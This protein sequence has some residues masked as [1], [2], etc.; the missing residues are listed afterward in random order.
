MFSAD[1]LP[2]NYPWAEETEEK[3]GK[4]SIESGTF[5]VNQGT[6]KKYVSGFCSEA[7]VRSVTEG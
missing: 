4:N 7:W 3:N 5:K 1:K 2:S 6:R